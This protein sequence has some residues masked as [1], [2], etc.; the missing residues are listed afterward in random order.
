MARRIR[1]PRSEDLLA[2]AVEDP[3]LQ[4]ARLGQ[5]RQ[6]RHV[7]PAVGRPVLGDHEDL[8][9]AV[10]VRGEPFDGPD[11]LVGEPRARVALA[12][13]RALVLANGADRSAVGQTAAEPLPGD[14]PGLP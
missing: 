1:P 9:G 14:A 11:L 3:E 13:Y 4:P 2:V 6:H 8:R 10:R 5:P 7:T 12:E